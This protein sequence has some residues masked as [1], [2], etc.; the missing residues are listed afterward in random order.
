MTYN[1]NFIK[2][3][4]FTTVFFRYFASFLFIEYVNYRYRGRILFVPK[5]NSFHDN[6]ARLENNINIL[7]ITKYFGNY[8]TLISIINIKILM[9]IVRIYISNFFFLHNIE[10][11]FI[12]SWLYRINFSLNHDYTSVL[13]SNEA[14]PWIVMNVVNE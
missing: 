8:S 10:L 9:I 2:N 13:Y 6:E 14:S 4:L 7:L 11:I 3:I 5:I 1:Y 12:D